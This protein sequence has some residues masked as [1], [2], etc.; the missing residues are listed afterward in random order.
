MKKNE[1]K[2]NYKI[3]SYNSLD[4]LFIYQNILNI[5]RRIIIHLNYGNDWNILSFFF[6]LVQYLLYYDYYIYISF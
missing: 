2:I 3:Y 1:L 4:I 6:F 5:W